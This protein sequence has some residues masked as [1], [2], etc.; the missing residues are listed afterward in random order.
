LSSVTPGAA[1]ISTNVLHRDLPFL[2]R[3]IR[4]CSGPAQFLAPRSSK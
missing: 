3:C 2:I 1:A 4:Q